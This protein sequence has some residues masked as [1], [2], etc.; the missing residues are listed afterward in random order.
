[1][2]DQGDSRGAGWVL[3]ASIVMIV[4]G[5][6]SALVG[7]FALIDGDK[8]AAL[9]QGRFLLVD[10]TTW[11]WGQLI[12]GAGVL[13]VG[14]G[15]MTGSSLAQVLA[16]FIVAINAIGQVFTISVYPWWGITAL[17]MDIFVIWALCVYR[18]MKF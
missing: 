5:G 3:F 1:M 6:W 4:T 18:P 17:V 7:L 12:L 2:A 16:V 10:A 13:F 14:L 8:V 11:G 9:G 15:L